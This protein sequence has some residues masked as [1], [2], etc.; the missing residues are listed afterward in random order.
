MTRSAI[1]NLPFTPWTRGSG[2][3]PGA[4]K[5]P[6]ALRAT[7]R[8]KGVKGPRFLKPQ[9]SSLKPFP[10]C[11]WLLPCCL[12]ALAS[13][14]FAGEPGAV[15]D[16]YVTLSYSHKVVQ[17]DGQTGALVG[18]FVTP[19][20]G[21]LDRAWG[22]TWGPNGNLFVVSEGYGENAGIIEYD[23]T[24]GA[25]VRWVVGPGD[26]NTW[27]TG[28]LSRP[29]HAVFGADGNLYVAGQWN[30]AIH[31]YDGLTGDWLG[32]FAI[33]GLPSGGLRIPQDLEFGPNGNLFVI[34]GY[35]AENP[36]GEG[37]GIFEY[38]HATG[39]LVRVIV[40]DDNPDIHMPIGASL[41]FRPNGNLLLT[42]TDLDL[43]TGDTYRN[44]VLEF[45][46]QTGELLGALVPDGS[47]LDRGT[48]M[49]YGPNGN[50]FVA[51]AN[52]LEILEFDGQTG[53]LVGTFASSGVSPYPMDLAFKPAPLDSMPAPAVTGISVSEAD[54]CDALIGVTVSG[55]NLDTSKTIVK[56]AASGESDIVGVVT[57][58][59]AEA[60]QV[61][62]DLGAGIA[63]GTRDVVV[64][65]P[66]GQMDVLASAV[67]VA[68]CWAASEANLFVL[69][70]RHRANRII[71]GLFEFDGSSGD[72]IA[73]LVEDRTAG[74]YDLNLSTGFLF[75]HDG[76]LLVTSNNPH[77]TG[78]GHFG[79][80]LQYDGI[81]G[82]RL[83]TFIPAGTAGMQ[84]PIKLR[85]GP[86]G[87]LFVLHEGPAGV[88]VLEFDG[89]SGAF[90]REFVSLNQCGL[91]K[92]ED[93]RFGPTD[94][95]YIVDDTNAACDPYIF[96]NAGVH[97]FDGLTGGCLAN[98]LVHFPVLPPPF[99]ARMRTFAFGPEDGLIYVPT[100]GAN[101]GGADQGA[102]RVYD[103]E[104]GA[105]LGEPIPLT[106]TLSSGMATA[107]FGPSG[108][109]FVSHVM[110]GQ[111]GY[112]SEY[113]IPDLASGTWL[114]VF[115]T[116]TVPGSGSGAAREII[117][118]PLLGD[119][120]GDWDRDLADFAALQRAFGGPGVTPANYNDL[121]F[122]F[123]RDGDVDADDF[124]EFA[125]RMTPPKDWSA[126]TGPCCLPDG[127][128]TENTTA[129]ECV[130]DL[131]G[132]WLG[133]AATCADDCPAFGA[134]CDPIDGS[135]SVLT[136]A[137]CAAYDGTYQGDATTC[138][139]D[140]CPFGR[141]S[142]E[143]DPMT[144]VALAGAGLEIAD[145]MT[146]EGTGA[147]D[148]VYMDLA[149]YGNGGGAFD[150][151]VALWTDCPGAGG[152][153]LPDTTFTWTGIPDDGFVYTLLGDLSAA[154]VTIPDTTWMVATFSNA[155]AGWIIAEQAELGTTQ[156]L[157]ARS[158]PWTCNATFGGTYAGLWANL[159]CVEGGGK[160]SSSSGTP[161]LRMEAVETAVSL[162][163][164]GE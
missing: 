99:M 84:T 47:G 115:A 39:R 124:P 8:V 41:L 27:E 141:Y 105:F 32:T 155:S 60:L 117:F 154:P 91:G 9:A 100:G 13:P 18:D 138:G 153:D 145:D 72:L 58:G 89:L 135:C 22:L 65:N 29:S 81:T 54:A 26:V 142:N 163:A 158:N 21:G 120:N 56:L 96:P 146:L 94:D 38:H 133:S 131:G 12:L 128:C 76:N 34:S 97:V 53:A 144:S 2:L 25:F 159:R 16:L 11:L 148:L 88:G 161:V 17:F 126:P 132:S 24:T 30:S 90:A 87:N 127:G 45:D 82:R 103:P 28:W 66:D 119:A 150:V 86:N 4:A 98:P 46:G 143:I 112:I 10:R 70:Y 20:S 35:E 137:Q 123:D 106:A 31:E 33:G 110:D 14:A 113:D 36:S 6:L 107:T 78:A 114:G 48:G 151:T 79:S 62:F 42:S 52:A 61:D 129:R 51:S 73:M 125:K 160:S 122:D 85:F 67:E 156:D 152:V 157:Y 75:G 139:V 134:C 5:Q 71:H 140:A 77:D 7:P 95:L 121:T 68:P 69:G 55:T 3:R 50:L 118:K 1:R 19:G 23:G 44:E 108:H 147:R 15:G 109:L 40:G 162:E 43:V 111:P 104:T 116:Q 83:G 80:V 59:A 93:F 64:V 130:V 164:I 74:G 101:C 92:V 57:G 49:T 149:V 37:R 63:G 102:V 136:E